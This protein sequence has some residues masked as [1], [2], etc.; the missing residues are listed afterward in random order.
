MDVVVTGSSGLIGSALVPALAE[1]G[2]WVVRLVRSG[3]APGGSDTLR[4]DPEAGTIDAAGLEGVG[5]VVH[6]AGEGIG[7]R[8]WTEAHKARI[9]DSRVLGTRLLAETLAKS[10]RPPAVLVSA[11]AVGIYGDRGDE[12]LTEDSPPGHGFLA[13]VAR[14]WEAATAPAEKAGIRVSHLRSG[15]VLSAKGG[16]LQ[17][18]LTP[19]RL[20]IGG[21]LGSGRQWMSWISIDD[22]VGAILHLLGEGAPAGPVNSTAPNT[23]TNAEFTEA[24]GKALHRPTAL[25][26]PRAG[27]RLL[28]GGEMAEELLLGGQRVLPTRLLG[29]GYAFRA[30]ELGTALELVLAPAS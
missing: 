1:A 16:A 18:M 28:L 25:P 24:L 2:H 13:E 5:G 14:E 8:R 12:T 6:L 29:S 30:P 20:G 4:W 21:R 26:V 7:N 22:E 27:L 9:R 15:I 17:K 3:G 10:G 19:F 23:V 11:S